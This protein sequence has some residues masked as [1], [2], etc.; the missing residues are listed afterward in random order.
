MKFLRMFAAAAAIALASNAAGAVPDATG[1]SVFEMQNPPNAMAVEKNADIQI[2]ADWICYAEN[3]YGVE[4][5]WVGPSKRSAC[6]SVMYTCRIN[7]PVGAVCSIT[8]YERY[9]G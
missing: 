7:T 3:S 5:Y 2:A 4:F 8:G 1:T 9:Y 6:N